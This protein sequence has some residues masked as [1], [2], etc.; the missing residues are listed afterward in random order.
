MEHFILA[1]DKGQKL[2]GALGSN[3]D[4]VLLGTILM[5]L[6]IGQCMQ[7]GCLSEHAKKSSSASQNFLR[8]F[9][10]DPKTF[11]K[12]ISCIESHH[13]V[14]NYH[15]REAEICANADCYRFLSPEGFFHGLLIFSNRYGNLNEALKALEAKIEEKYRALSLD[16]CKQELGGYYHQF[17]K[18]IEAAKTS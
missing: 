15:C 5:D 13:G 8:Q 4:I 10:L 2:A 17:K 9:D 3:K 12:I 14:K 11:Q 16:I 18:L 1:N 6:K 7:E